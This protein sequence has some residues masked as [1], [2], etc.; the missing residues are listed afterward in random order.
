MGLAVMKS[1]LKNTLRMIKNY[2]QL[3]IY[4]SKKLFLRDNKIK[5]FFIIIK[6][7]FYIRNFEKKDF[8]L[9]E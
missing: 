8:I 9:D 2:F 4:S 3:I 1:R 5:F 6:K 7:H